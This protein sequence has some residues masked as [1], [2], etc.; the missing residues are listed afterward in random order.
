MTELIY[1]CKIAVSIRFFA[2][3]YYAKYSSLAG[4]LTMHLVQYF[5]TLNFMG[6]SL[7]IDRMILAHQAANSLVVDVLGLYLKNDC[8]LALYLQTDEEALELETQMK[9]LVDP[10]YGYADYRRLLEPVKMAQSNSV[11]KYVK[12]KP[13]G[14][15]VLGYVDFISSKSDMELAKKSSCSEALSVESGD[16]IRLAHPEYAAHAILV[17]DSIEEHVGDLVV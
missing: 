16:I 2:E 1:Y 13:V 5:A 10:T 15:K 11:Y 9:N 17:A 8:V 6:N 12:V 7:F 3:Y 4:A 14:R